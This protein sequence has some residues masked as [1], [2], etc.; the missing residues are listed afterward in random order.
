MCAHLFCLHFKFAKLF[1]AKTELKLPQ[2]AD[3][4]FSIVEKFIIIIFA[5][6][7]GAYISLCF[8]PPGAGE[9]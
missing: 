7:P 9:Y 8:G 6:L 2:F 4:L 1:I 3:L 5:Y